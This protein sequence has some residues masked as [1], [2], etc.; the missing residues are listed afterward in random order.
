MSRKN[1]LA[2]SMGVVIGIIVTSVYWRSSEERGKFR[3]DQNFKCQQ[4]AKR[5]ETENN[6]PR[7]LVLLLKVAYSPT[8]NSCVAEVMKIGNGSIDYTLE[9][10]FSRD[11]RIVFHRSIQDAVNDPQEPFGDQK[12]FS[13]YDAQFSTFAR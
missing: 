2:L 13:D 3:F 4:I 7:H 12:L 1:W 8:R 5:Y 9:D 6:L 10:L 11:S